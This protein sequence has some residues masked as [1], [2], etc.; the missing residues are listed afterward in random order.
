M[1]IIVQATEEGTMMKGEE[2]EEED[3]VVRDSS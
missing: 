2:E 1:Q 3:C